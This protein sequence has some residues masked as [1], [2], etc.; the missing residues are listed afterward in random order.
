[1]SD[2]ILAIAG[3]LY[4]AGVVGLSSVLVGRGLGRWQLWTGWAVVWVLT[5]TLVL[6]SA[7]PEVLPFAPMAVGLIVAVSVGLP[8][9]IAVRYVDRRMGVS[10][11]RR[12]WVDALFAGCMF[13]YALV[14]TPV[15][16][17]AIGYVRL[18]IGR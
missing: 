15:V 14:F 2:G 9:G 4:I 8:T 10:S 18:G 1:V 7:R 17:L 3:L 16:I 6:L 5:T 12:W 13:L 11:M